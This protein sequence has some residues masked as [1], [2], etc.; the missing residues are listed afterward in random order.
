MAYKSFKDFISEEDTY[1]IVQT[2]INSK[3]LENPATIQALNAALAK[4]TSHPFITPYIGLGAIARVLA[5]ANI[6]LPQYIFMDKEQGEVVF[7]ATHFG[8]V[9]GVDVKANKV[10]ED[11]QTKYYVYY[12]YSMNDDGYY[13]VYAELVPDTD[14]S[15]LMDDA[16]KV[17]A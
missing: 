11:D 16:E 13:D 17:E 6:I 9:D 8:K 12:S 10:S 4:T 3:G 14:L 15:N 5:Y 2:G 7:D 1:S